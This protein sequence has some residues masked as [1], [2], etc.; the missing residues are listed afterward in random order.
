MDQATVAA[1]LKLAAALKPELIFWFL[2]VLIGTPFG[3]VVVIMLFWWL[4][5][6]R[7]SELMRI[8][9]EDVTKVTRYYEENVKL[10]EALLKIANGFQDTVVLN[11][12]TTQRMVDVCLTNQFCPNARLPK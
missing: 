2:V 3:L 5:E 4:N 6:R 9:R 11:T 7:A 12:Q 1:L 10:V 8:Y